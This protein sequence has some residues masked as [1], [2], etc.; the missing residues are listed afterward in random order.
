MKYSSDVLERVGFLRSEVW[1]LL[2]KEGIAVPVVLAIP[3]PLPPDWPGWKQVMAALPTF[4][5]SEPASA[6]AGVDPYKRVA[7][8]QMTSC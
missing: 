8:D 7:I 1:P 4:P 6:F 2:V 3:K 5:V